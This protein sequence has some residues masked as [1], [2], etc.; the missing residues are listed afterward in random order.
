MAIQTG[1]IYY[2]Y[3]EKFYCLY[4]GDDSYLTACDNLVA[5]MN[6]QDLAIQNQNP[7]DSLI[8]NQNTLA[9]SQRGNHIQLFKKAL[10]VVSILVAAGLIGA[11]TVLFSPFIAV[12]LIPV[13]GL[14]SL[15]LYEVCK[16]TEV[17][18]VDNSS[19]KQLIPSVVPRHIVE[20]NVRG[21]SHELKV[22]QDIVDNQDL[23]V[24]SIDN[25]TPRAK[26]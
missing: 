3:K 2:S 9:R 13:L 19:H 17:V 24:R 8:K 15:G 25:Q 14:S 7:H 6:P 22:D 1:M 18:S 20:D 11:A 21:T 23:N 5:L 10:I 12:A 4:Q 26:R 16:K